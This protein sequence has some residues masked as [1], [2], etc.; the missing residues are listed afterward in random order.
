MRQDTLTDAMR[1]FRR[2]SNDLFWWS[3]R[4]GAHI[5]RA[6]LF[7]A[8]LTRIPSLPARVRAVLHH[9]D[10]PANLRRVADEIIGQAM[11]EMRRQRAHAGPRAHHR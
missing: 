9:P 10:P 7:S 3:E 5:V 6:P 4:Y 11:Q 2:S 1:L 8:D